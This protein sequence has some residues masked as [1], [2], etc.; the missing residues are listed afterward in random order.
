MKTLK[1]K[2]KQKQKKTRTLRG[3]A[4][5][6]DINN[7]KLFIINNLQSQVNKLTLDARLNELIKK[8]I[9]DRLELVIQESATT[10]QYKPDLIE[11]LINDLNEIVRK[12]TNDNAY[13]NA[14]NNT[15]KEQLNQLRLILNSQKNNLLQWEY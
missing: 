3:G 12:A 6:Q 13:N 5:L 7:R 14:Y 15:Y 10:N 4:N 9:Q 2:Q 8:W 1:K 11:W